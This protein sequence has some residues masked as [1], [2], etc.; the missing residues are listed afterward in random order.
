MTGQ[1]VP[2][3]SIT[4]DKNRDKNMVVSPGGHCLES[5]RWLGGFEESAFREG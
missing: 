2:S 3:R 5:L 1:P 4:R